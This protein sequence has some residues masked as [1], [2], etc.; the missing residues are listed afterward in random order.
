[1]AL[2]LSLS[3]ALFIVLLFLPHACVTIFQVWY[4]RKMLDKLIIKPTEG[5]FLQE[6]RGND[7]QVVY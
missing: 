5:I 6:L 4:V 1:M 2:D 3:L 7:S